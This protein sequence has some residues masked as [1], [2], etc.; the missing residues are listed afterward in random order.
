MTFK[1]A[2]VG[3]GAIGTV[4]A[5]SLATAGRSVT[6]VARGARR[7]ELVNRG[8]RFIERGLE[9]TVFPRI[10]E[11]SDVG[12]ADLVVMATKAHSLAEVLPQ[13]VSAMAPEAH[14]VPMVN[15]IPWWYFLGSQAEAPVRSVDPDGKLL[16]LI[17]GHRILGCVVYSRASIRDQVATSHGPQFMKLGS[18]IG[19]PPVQVAEFFSDA[20]IRVGVETDIRR[21]VWRKLVLNAA[22]NPV[23]ALM[24]ATLEQLA[25][26][27][28]LSEC[29][30]G[31]AQEVLDLSVLFGYHLDLAVDSIR[32][33][34]Q[35]GGRF[36]T[37]MLQDISAGRHPEFGA[38]I[39]APLELASVAAHPMPRLQQIASLLRAKVRLGETVS[40][41]E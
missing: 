7:E 36:A 26:D 28:S 4:V 40:A 2:I 19:P 22:T 32:E 16:P 29:V 1:V 20:G 27:P 6:I 25:S 23:S 34:V 8:L 38:V 3:A 15:G 9:R 37:S 41:A 11:L 5:A 12:Q 14:L 13:V 35:R 24:G 30:C 17:N 21:E 33:Q 10:A 18:V 39:D 31:I